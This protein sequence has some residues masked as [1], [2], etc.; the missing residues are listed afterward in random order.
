[1][2]GAVRPGWADNGTECACGVGVQGVGGRRGGE[3]GV[4]SWPFSRWTRKLEV[5]FRF[6]KHVAAAEVQ[7][8]AYYD[9][10]GK[11]SH[12]NADQGVEKVRA[13]IRAALGLPAAK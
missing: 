5:I 7:A 1:M 4:T 12:I 11:T 13:D 10:Q 2:A 3:G 9:K 6:E 8:G